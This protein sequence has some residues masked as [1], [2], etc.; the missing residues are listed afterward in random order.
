MREDFP[1]ANP[2]PDPAL[3]NL[4][5]FRANTLH[6]NKKRD[7][8]SNHLIQRFKRG[9]GWRE[10]SWGRYRESEYLPTLR[11]ESSA[12]IGLAGKTRTTNEALRSRCRLVTEPNKMLL[13]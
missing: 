6:L 9:G 7:T 1:L 12:E 10:E 4:H 2:R 3:P 8:T 11:L 13:I 5:K